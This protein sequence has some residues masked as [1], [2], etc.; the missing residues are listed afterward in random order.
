MGLAPRYVEAGDDVA[1][2]I[3]GE[4]PLVVCPNGKGSYDFIGECIYMASWMA[5]LSTDSSP[6]RARFKGLKLAASKFLIEL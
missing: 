3:G 4:I 2:V 6:R 1:I 5:R